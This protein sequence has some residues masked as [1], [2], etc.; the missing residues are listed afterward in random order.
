MI[1]LIFGIKELPNPKGEGYVY[2][3]LGPSGRE[4][5]VDFLDLYK[6][7]DE[8]LKTL[9]VSAAQK[10]QDALIT[11]GRHEEVSQKVYRTDNMSG[12]AIELLKEVINNY[13]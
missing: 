13:W 5:F 2:Y 7:S 4:Y 1:M 8:E 11:N 3:K 6:I 12:R 10:A 9:F